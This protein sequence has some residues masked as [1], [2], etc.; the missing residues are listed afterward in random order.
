[1]ASECG[2]G[3]ND[4]THWGLSPRAGIL[5]Q[6]QGESE[7]GVGGV[8][9]RLRLRICRP[10]FPPLLLVKTSHKA[11]NGEIDSTPRHGGTVMAHGRRH[12]YRE[13]VHWP[14]GAIKLP[15]HLVQVLRK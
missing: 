9:L 15:T 10:S 13:A 14:I 8:L 7:A 12:R 4:C 6:R 3:W 2:I 5:H 11:K 1:M